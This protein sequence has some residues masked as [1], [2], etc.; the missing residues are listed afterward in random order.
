MLAARREL[1]R[2][3]EWERKQEELGVRVAE[4]AYKREQRAH[5]R[6]EQVEED[7]RAAALGGLYLTKAQRRDLEYFRRLEA[8]VRYAAV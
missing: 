4:M 8:Q 7:H 1:A 6:A 3:A 5:A 2:R